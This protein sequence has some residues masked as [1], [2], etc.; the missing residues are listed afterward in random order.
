MELKSIRRSKI[1]IPEIWDNKKEKPE[2]QIKVNISSFPSGAQ[3]GS[4]KTFRFKDGATEVSYDNI[5]MMLSHVDNI[6]NLKIG[7]ESIDT[8]VK[9]CDFNDSRL[10]DLIV[11]IRLYLLKESEDLTE[12]ES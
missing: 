7:G 8:P 6:E 5:N 9:L 3:V 4:Y 10:Y 12:R 2:N 1:F 11:A